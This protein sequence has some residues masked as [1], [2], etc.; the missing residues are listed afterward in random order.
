MRD[1]DGTTTEGERLFE[2]AEQHRSAYIAT[3]GAVGHVVDYRYLGGYRFSTCLLIETIGRKSGKRRIT[4][5][6]YGTT[7]G[8]V[9]L[10]S[11][12]SGA[13]AHPAWHLNL[14]AMDQ[15]NIQIAGQAFRCTWRELAG[16]E[17][18]ATWHLMAGIYPT[19]RDYQS[20]TAREIPIVCL[21]PGEEIDV[22]QA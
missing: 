21:A 20:R 15:V 12:H 10:V 13:E 3:K 18:A 2:T 16:E 1:K 14:K 22:L 8:E 19:Y 9:V 6:I 7:G 4:P 17:R 11:S 5:L